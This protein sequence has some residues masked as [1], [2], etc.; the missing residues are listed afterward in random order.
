MRSVFNKNDLVL[1]LGAGTGEV[2]LW[3]NETGWVQAH[4]Y[5]YSKDIQLITFNKVHFLR[6]VMHD[7]LLIS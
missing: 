6:Y 7:W 4:A 5:D 3:L 2:S 1:E